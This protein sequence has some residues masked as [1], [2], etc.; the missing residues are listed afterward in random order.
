MDAIKN[1]QISLAIMSHVAAGKSLPEA[2]DAVMGAG[3]Y[4]KLAGEVYEAARAKA[5][6]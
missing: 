5:G 2:Y 3:A 4:V 1:V 6:K